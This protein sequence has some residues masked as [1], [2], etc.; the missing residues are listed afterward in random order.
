V[1][2]ELTPKNFEPL[3]APP[4]GEEPADWRVRASLGG[5]S[6]PRLDALR[7]KATSFSKVM[8]D[9]R[10]KYRMQT[11]PNDPTHENMPLLS[12]KSK[13]DGPEGLVPVVLANEQHPT[14]GEMRSGACGVCKKTCKFFS[15]FMVALIVAIGVSQT[16]ACGTDLAANA[17]PGKTTPGPDACVR[18]YNDQSQDEHLLDKLLPECNTCPA[19]ADHACDEGNRDTGE[20]GECP[21][22]T[23]GFD[24][25]VTQ[26]TKDAISAADS[27]AEMQTS[28]VLL[29]LL[30]FGW[31]TVTPFILCGA[32]CCCKN[33]CASCRFEAIPVI[34]DMIFE[35]VRSRSLA[36]VETT[37][38]FLLA[39]AAFFDAQM[40]EATFA[41]KPSVSGFSAGAGQLWPPSLSPNVADFRA[42]DD[43]Q[44][45]GL[46]G[47]FLLR[48]LMGNLSN[49]QWQEVGK[50][51]TGAAFSCALFFS[52][53]SLGFLWADVGYCR[54]PTAV[55]R[56]DS[57][58]SYCT[59]FGAGLP[60]E[61]MPV[62]AFMAD[63]DA[64]SL[65]M[66]GRKYFSSSCTYDDCV[67]ASQVN[68]SF[69]QLFAPTTYTPTSSL[70]FPAETP[71]T[72]DLLPS[73]GI[74]FVRWAQKIAGDTARSKGVP[75]LIMDP[76]EPVTCDATD[77]DR[78]CLYEAGSMIEAIQMYAEDCEDNVRMRD[79]TLLV[80]ALFLLN[81]F[82]LLLLL[83]VNS[84]CVSTNPDGASLSLS[85]FTPIC[86]FLC[87]LD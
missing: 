63:C 39:A 74:D 32:Y 29:L 58:L 13:H 44:K 55:H 21:A 53:W 46:T 9:P 22:G 37:G 2:M 6:S 51:L 34:S 78:P 83:K 1:T 66:V 48:F 3:R 79:S 5:G 54:Y 25:A 87:R 33:Q 15:L 41:L 69:A 26:Q 35:V 77:P 18:T 38:F 67:L 40:C 14:F 65:L 28:A 80:S 82:E 45:L 24:C 20:I 30:G 59:I 27:S 72:V 42:D 31:F 52:V 64:Q 16:A 81:L 56:A 7:T 23:D 61:G 49:N 8:L 86:C 4:A 70:Q 50:N 60:D 71:A 17:A 62:K 84:P 75:G 10:E 19:K 57:E 12:Q 76:P 73:K 11:D 43:Y 85:L 36:V 47:L 68:V